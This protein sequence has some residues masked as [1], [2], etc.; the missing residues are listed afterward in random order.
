M[1]SDELQQRR[2]RLARK[3]LLGE[4]LNYLDRSIAAIDDKESARDFLQTIEDFMSRKAHELA[5][6][7]KR[8]GLPEGLQK[9]QRSKSSLSKVES[10][11]QQGSD[12]N[13]KLILFSERSQRA[14]GAYGKDIEIDS[15]SVHWG[16]SGKVR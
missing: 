16:V 10:K 4:D 15:S 8:L 1:C 3:S 2:T 12:L 5:A 9:N 14:R 11:F 6:V 13:G 7:R